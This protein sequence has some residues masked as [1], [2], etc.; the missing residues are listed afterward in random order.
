MQDA[1]RMGHLCDV[2]AMRTEIV[3]FT[4]R[5]LVL[6]ASGCLR[7]CCNAP[8]I[9]ASNEICARRV[10]LPAYFTNRCCRTMHPF[11]RNV[12]RSPILGLTERSSIPHSHVG[13]IGPRG[14]RCTLGTRPGARRALWSQQHKGA[15]SG[16]NRVQQ[17]ARVTPIP[18]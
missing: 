16:P 17:C 3:L 6:C 2:H 15:R 5:T 10:R 1:H 7:L 8:N 14:G 18:R 13:A 4:F 9:R 12:T 11:V